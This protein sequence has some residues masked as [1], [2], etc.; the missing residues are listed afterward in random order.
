MR[1]V[2]RRTF[3]LGAER[4]EI[5]VGE[6]AIHGS[7]TKRRIACNAGTAARMKERTACISEFRMHGR[8][9]IPV[10]VWQTETPLAGQLLADPL[11]VE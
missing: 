11:E 4:K 3:D 6:N 5:I 8:I 10:P 2:V 7:V 1:S 9:L